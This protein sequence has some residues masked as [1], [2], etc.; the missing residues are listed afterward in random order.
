MQVNTGPVSQDGQP[1]NQAGMLG[2][3]YDKS[4][5]IDSQLL[6]SAHH[7]DEHTQAL[8]A[9]AAQQSDRSTEYAIQQLQGYSQ[10][11]DDHQHPHQH[12]QLQHHQHHPDENQ[13]GQGLPNG[14]VPGGMPQGLANGL[15]GQG[16]P[17]HLSGGL[18]HHSG[19]QMGGGMPQGLS[20][21]LGGQMGSAVRGF[22]PSPTS[23]SVSKPAVGSEEYYRIKKYN[24]KEV[25]RRRRETI[26]KGID[27]LGKVVPDCDK[28]KGQILGRAV[29]YIK[30]LKDK[31]ET[32]MK[33]LTL[34]KLIS[35]QSINE[36]QSTI[37][38]LKTELAQAW[39]EIEH[40][41][42]QSETQGE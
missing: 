35:E 39:K 9:A 28:H 31:E 20:S 6:Q 21:G 29:D 11:K 4:M 25:E 7:P 37:K 15:V 18:G 27:D 32:L 5:A 22:V 40:Y 1:G 14:M 3:P 33:Q 38:S 16:I 41:K 2:R 10:I 8:A 13:L 34:E 42:R 36:L 24:H 19:L 30:M 23:S 12:H 17:N 26:N